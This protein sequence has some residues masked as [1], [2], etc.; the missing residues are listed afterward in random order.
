MGR[1]GLV[2]SELLRG[3]ETEHPGVR[4]RSRPCPGSRARELL[5]AFAGDATPDIAQLGNTWLPEFQQLGAL[6]PLEPWIAQSALPAD[7]YFP[8]SGPPTWPAA[9]RGPALVCGHTAALR[10]SRPAGPRRLAA[11]AA[12][13]G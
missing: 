13:L 9:T 12:D 3:F 1:E 7:D 10:A 6:E 4:V 8:A 2:A 11:D 5:T